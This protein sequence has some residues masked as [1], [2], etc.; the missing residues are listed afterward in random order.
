MEKGSDKKIPSTWYYT[1]RLNK[2]ERLKLWRLIDGSF[3]E[4]L[5]T[6]NP[7]GVKN[8]QNFYTPS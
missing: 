1:D 3:R 8:E 7:V 5:V 4:E 6:Q 2:V